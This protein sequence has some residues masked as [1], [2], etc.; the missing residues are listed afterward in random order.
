MKFFV[1]FHQFIC[2]YFKKET[3]FLKSPKEK[4]IDQTKHRDDKNNLFLK[5]L[6]LKNKIWNNYNLKKIKQ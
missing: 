5:N 1:Y 6:N 3:K 4:D 2:L